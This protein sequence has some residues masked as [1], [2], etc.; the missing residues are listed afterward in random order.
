[1]ASGIAVNTEAAIVSSATIVNFTGRRF[2]GS[3]V[4]GRN[5]APRRRGGDSR[6]VFCG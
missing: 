2:Q 6:S 1:V 5:S 4:S 3:K